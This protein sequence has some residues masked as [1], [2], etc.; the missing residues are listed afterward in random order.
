MIGQNLRSK[1]IT[2]FRFNSFITLGQIGIWETF[3]Q[4]NLTQQNDFNGQTQQRLTTV[5]ATTNNLGGKRLR[6]YSQCSEKRQF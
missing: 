6:D 2:D 4:S 5:P 1:T 3:T